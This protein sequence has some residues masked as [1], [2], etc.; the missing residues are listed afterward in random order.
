[1]STRDASETVLAGF[2]IAVMA[3]AVVLTASRSGS[4]CLAVAILVFGL[5]LTRKQPSRSRRLIGAAYLVTVLLA[6]A[7]LGGVEVVAQRF[8]NAA[9]PS[10]DGRVNVWKDT[11]HIIQDAPWSGTG[12]NTYGIAMLHYQTVQDG[13]Q[14][15]EAHNDYLQL[16]A[17]GGVLLGVPMLVALG[18]FVREAWRRFHEGA[19]DARTY[20]LRAGAVT[21]LGAIAVQ[22]LFDFTL[23]MPGAAAL[24]VV[25]GAIAIHRPLHAHAAA[26]T[27][28]IGRI[29]TI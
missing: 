20:W 8:Y 5:W 9:W 2:S 28:P 27:P 3:V 22:E 4:V 7:L 19:D 24:F 1:L 16:A 18:L 23:Q 13:S 14:Y 26:A 15:I 29:R 11:V 6:A 25:L 10:L 12:F 17:E 21:G